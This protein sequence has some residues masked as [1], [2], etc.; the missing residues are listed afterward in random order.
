M[1]F[2]QVTMTDAEDELRS[3]L[4]SLIA[5]ELPPGSYEPGLGMGAPFSPDF[6]RMLAANGYLG[7]AIPA[8]YGGHGRS[9]VERFIVNEELLAV[10]APISAHYVADRQ[11]GPTIL[12]F[13]TESQRRKFL[14]PI[15]QGKWFFSIALSEPDSGS[16]LASVRTTARRVDGGWLLNGT[17]VWTSGAHRNHYALALC[18]TSKAEDPHSGL[19]QFIVALDG[20]GIQINP[21]LSMDRTHSFNELVFNDA[22]VP[23]D[24]LLGEEG[25]GWKQVNSELSYERSGP[26]RFLSPFTLYAAYVRERLPIDRSPDVLRVVGELAARMWIIRR[27]SLSVAKSLDAGDAPAIESAMVKDI[28]T[29]FEQHVVHQLSILAAGEIPR[30]SQGGFESLLARAVLAAPTFTLRG[31]TTEVLR[32]VVARG[33]DAIQSGSFTGEDNPVE[34]VVSQIISDHCPPQEVDAAEVRPDGW[35]ERTWKAL[36]EAG[37]PW[38]SVPED[39]GGSGGTVKDMCAALRRIGRAAVPVPVGETGLLAGW[40]LAG[41][42]LVIPTEPLTVIDGDGAGLDLQRSGRR[43]R[44]RGTAE[45]VPWACV[46]SALIVLVEVDGVPHVAV[47]PRAATTIERNSN[48][49]GEPRDRVHFAD[50]QLSDEEVVRAGAGADRAALRMRGALI[51]ASCMAGAMEAVAESSVAH[52]RERQQFGRPIARYQA[53]Q[54]HLVVIAEEAACAALAARYAAGALDTREGA[55]GVEV[56]A[57]KAVAGRAAAVV[58]ARAHQVHG[59]LGTTQEHPLQL[60]TRRLWAWDKE[61]GS[62]TEWERHLGAVIADS[63]PSALWPLVVEGSKALRPSA[64]SAREQRP[65]TGGWVEPGSPT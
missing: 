63:D 47:V 37:I 54:H 36:A 60:L 51:R 43:W 13:G 16:D 12:R 34:D 35:S 4:R 10:G 40:L 20:P 55:L 8:E 61:F 1:K 39:L 57:A 31:G 7:M 65:G 52:A 29:V 23:D 2:V 28:G 5:H 21:I 56:A 49:A 41:A 33:L 22:F 3:D 24:A 46:A 30:G 27:L 26:D 59:A 42:G 14:P 45:M 64:E 32:S 18:R 11:S 44:L 58:T 9:A 62:A 17:K 6:S 25:M 15:C 48:L 53:V 19:S 50:V 38:I